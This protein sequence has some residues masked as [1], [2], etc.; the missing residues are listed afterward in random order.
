[1]RVRAGL[2]TSAA[3]LVV[4]AGGCGGGAAPAPAGSAP[5]VAV[6]TGEPWYD[7]TGP[8]VAGG[9]VGAPGTA[10]ALPVSFDVVPSWRVTAVADDKELAAF[11]RSG[12][13]TM[14]C[15]LN[16]RPVGT[17][18]FLRVHLVDDVAAAPRPALTA[19]LTAAGKL[20]E[21]E[22]RDITVGGLPAVEATY[23]HDGELAANLRQ[24]SLAVRAPKGVVLLTL[25]GLEADDR[26]TMLPAY[27]LARQSMVA[28]G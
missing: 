24:R 16:A 21:V 2:M 10:C 25:S 11:T 17:I 28:T 8:A 27:L 12:G 7:E 15:E 13:A 5:V 6:R 19:F 18:G 26:E 22:Y 20:R 3:L 4:V 14:V 9:K 1:M 23:L